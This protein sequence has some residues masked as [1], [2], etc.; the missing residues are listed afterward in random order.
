[1]NVGGMILNSGSA[2]SIWAKVQGPSGSEA[3]RYDTPFTDYTSTT[4][5]APF[6]G[7]NVSL[8]QTEQFIAVGGAFNQDSG[9]V[10]GNYYKGGIRKI[11]IYNTSFASGSGDPIVGSETLELVTNIMN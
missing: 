11:L 1:M 6:T 5:T 2:R 8:G 4:G 10:D 3:Y 9:S 7:S